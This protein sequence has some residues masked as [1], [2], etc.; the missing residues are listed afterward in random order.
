M[1]IYLEPKSLEISTGNIFVVLNEIRQ[2][3]KADSIEWGPSEENNG[4][5]AD[6][7]VL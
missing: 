7:G 4:H 1:A 5:S 2:S 6:Q 3:T